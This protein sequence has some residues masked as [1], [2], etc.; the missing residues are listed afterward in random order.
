MKAF[1]ELVYLSQGNNTI[2]GVYELKFNLKPPP[3]PHRQL[4][5]PVV[6]PGNPR[7]TFKPELP[8]TRTGEVG[9]PSLMESVFVTM[10]YRM[11]DGPKARA[12]K[13]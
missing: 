12:D 13:A 3:A 6:D 7:K 11:P 10:R 1:H 9:H 2:S 5:R 4:P 8:P